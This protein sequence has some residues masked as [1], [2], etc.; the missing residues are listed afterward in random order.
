M[1]L[2]G[3]W[4]VESGDFEISHR[5]AWYWTLMVL[6]PDHITPAMFKAA[7]DKVAEKH[8]N[9]SLAKLRLERF[10]E[11]RCVQALHVGSYM[12]EAP[13]IAR[14]EAY[15]TEH[16]YRFCG[17]HHEIY[18]GDPRRAKPEKLKTVLRHPVERAG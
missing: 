12:E 7:L 18:M 10:R 15:A 17:K 13:T 2:E 5:E 16:G 11:G 14:M 9:P 8:P 6:Q 1:A 3:L 4:W